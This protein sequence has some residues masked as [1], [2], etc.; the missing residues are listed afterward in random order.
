MEITEVR[1][2]LVSGKNDKLRAFCSITIDNDFVIR[3]L[4]VIDGAKGPF[5]AMP[6]RKLMNRCFKC[7]GK[8]HFRARFCNECGAKITGGAGGEGTARHG[9]SS[10]RVGADDETGDSRGKLHAEIAHPINSRCREMIQREVL[11][12]FEEEYK[13][14]ELPGYEPAGLHPGEG[15]DDYFQESPGSASDRRESAS[16]PAFDD[17]R[18]DPAS[19]K[20][21]VE[22]RRSAAPQPFSR[23]EIS[24]A[25]RDRREDAGRGP[26]SD[27]EHQTRRNPEGDPERR[28]TEAQP[29]SPRPEGDPPESS[30]S[31]PPHPG[32]EQ[33]EEAEDNFGAG[34]FS[35]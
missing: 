16:K 29:E 10:Q 25:T 20:K 33:A 1:V 12:K 34:I 9:Q 31:R 24:S 30:R 32:P 11:D 13:Q 17:P 2:K 6:S 35:F 28:E 7:G 4:K 22:A 26:G 23:E 3:D 27:F 19:T 8:N 5:V 15:Y 18:M 14:S 21:Q